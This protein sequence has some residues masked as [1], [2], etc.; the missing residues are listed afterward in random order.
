[1]VDWNK[2]VELSQTL[3][4]RLKEGSSPAAPAEAASA[5]LPAPEMPTFD[6]PELAPEVSAPPQ[7]APVPAPPTAQEIP[8]VAPVTRSQAPAADPVPWYKRE[9]SFGKKSNRK[10]KAKQPEVAAEPKE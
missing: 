10:P 7:P 9:L 8:S 4:Q 1:M 6:A 3:G 2:D 5:P